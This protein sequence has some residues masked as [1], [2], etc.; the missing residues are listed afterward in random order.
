MEEYRTW[1]ADGNPE[2]QQFYRDGKLEGE[3]KFWYPNGRLG[4]L[5]FYRNGKREGRSRLWYING[6]LESDESYQ[7]GKV[8]GKSIMYWQTSGWPGEQRFYRNG[9]Q[10]GEHRGWNRENGTL[11]YH[12]F[13]Q[14][15]NIKWNFSIKKKAIFIRIKTKLKF[16]TIK[17]FDILSGFLIQDL[18]M[19]S[20]SYL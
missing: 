9:T 7:N 2:L 18:M 8:E 19:S 12:H 10:E 3:R 11:E 5:Q 4:L 1:Y 20:L 15:E 14:N 13:I 16:R 6:Q 17:I